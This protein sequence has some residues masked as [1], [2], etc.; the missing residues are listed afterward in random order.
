MI[1]TIRTYL[2]SILLMEWRKNRKM[3]VLW[4]I[5]SAKIH[6]GPIFL[7]KELNRCNKSKEEKHIKEYWRICSGD[8]WVTW[9][10]YFSCCTSRKGPRAY[11]ALN[12]FQSNWKLGQPPDL[13]MDSCENWIQVETEG[14]E[15]LQPVYMIY[16]DD[17]SFKP[18][19]QQVSNKKKYSLNL[20]IKFIKMF[21]ECHCLDR[22][23]C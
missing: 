11:Q 15:A 21:W 9:G 14:Y 23:W 3:W 4:K 6:L 20:Y 13:W 5:C 17:F 19:S 18:A 12:I 1:T 22:G 16:S 7:C 2:I 8:G 10:W